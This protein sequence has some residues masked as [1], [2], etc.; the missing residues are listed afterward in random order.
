MSKKEEMFLQFTQPM[1]FETSDNYTTSGLD[2]IAGVREGS[3]VAKHQLFADLSQGGVQGDLSHVIADIRFPMHCA[4]LI[5]TFDSALTMEIY[6]YMCAVGAG[7]RGKC[8]PTVDLRV[9]AC[10]SFV[11]SDC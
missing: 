6:L 11:A 9:V 8:P 4:A 1:H 2:V 5:G 10:D 7:G 3:D